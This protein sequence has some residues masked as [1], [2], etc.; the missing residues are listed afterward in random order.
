MAEWSDF[1]HLHWPLADRLHDDAEPENPRQCFARLRGA[2]RA[3]LELILNAR[4]P[5]L[6]LPADALELRRSLVAFGLPDLAGG[7]LAGENDAE[8]FRRAVEEA[9]QLFVPAL[10]TLKVDLADP[11]QTGARLL[12]RIGATIQCG[13]ERWPLAFESTLTPDARRFHVSDGDDD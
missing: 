7:V 12:L 1:P 3:E 5:R 11:E 6:R 9:I 10:G 4:R 2:L 13:R 8:D